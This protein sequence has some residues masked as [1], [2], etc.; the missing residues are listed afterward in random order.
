MIRSSSRREVSCIRHIRESRGQGELSLRE[1]FPVTSCPE[2][3]SH[4]A[5]MILSKSVVE[6]EHSMIEVDSEIRRDIGIVALTVRN[7]CTMQKAEVVVSFSSD[8]VSGQ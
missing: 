5:L 3:V 7:W 4:N 1:H 8:S 6:F 2:Y